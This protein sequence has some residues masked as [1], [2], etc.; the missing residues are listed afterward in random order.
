M[1]IAEAENRTKTATA[2]H[3]YN[4]HDA[5]NDNAA[6]ATKI[7]KEP[8]VSPFK[9][10]FNKVDEKN[11][12]HF[13][14]FVLLFSI[15]VYL[16]FVMTIYQAQ[17]RK[18]WGAFTNEQALT[19]LY[20]TQ[21]GR[22]SVHFWVIYCL[23]VITTGV[24]AYQV[25]WHLGSPKSAPLG[26]TLT[27]ISLCVA[28]VALITLIRHTLLKVIAAIFPFYKEINLFSFTITIFHQAMGLLLVPFV[29]F[30]AF[31]PTTVQNIALYIG[32][33]IVVF[34]Y[35]YRSMRGF[36][37]A[38]KYILEYR[39]HFLLYLCAVEIAPMLILVKLGL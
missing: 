21:V 27:G 16:A 29:I 19:A 22:V 39:F 23:F 1:S 18:I 3:T 30:I 8:W 15:V 24:F 10:I 6:D 2:P 17:V 5:A 12:S 32:L 38:S 7:N 34:I 4:D 9:K 20:R 13:V 37:I 25:A 33:G 28:G 31:A 35:A 36:I 11:P 26:G 14:F